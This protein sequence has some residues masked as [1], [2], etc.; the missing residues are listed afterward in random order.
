MGG[1][2]MGGS[3]GI[4]SQLPVGHLTVHSEMGKTRCRQ[5]VVKPNLFHGST[6]LYCEVVSLIFLW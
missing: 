2:D 6:V 5:S 1:W 3:W 4:T